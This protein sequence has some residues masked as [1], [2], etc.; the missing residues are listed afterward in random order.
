MSYLF[1]LQ[2]GMLGIF[3]AKKKVYVFRIDIWMNI[4]LSDDVNFSE[5]FYE[6]K[7]S[8][9]DFFLEIAESNDP[10]LIS[11]YANNVVL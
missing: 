8:V 6:L 11:F 2:V 5:E 9:C 4:F 1:K 10:N 3:E 7:N